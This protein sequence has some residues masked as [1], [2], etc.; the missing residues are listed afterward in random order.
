MNLFEYVR[1][2]N[3]EGAVDEA[4]VPDA[5]YLAGGTTLV[6]LMRL[7]VER[8]KRVVDI[9]ALP[10][11][12]ISELP[13]GGVRIGALAKNSDVAHHRVI[14]E[15]FPVLSEA[16]LS[17]ASPQ[18]RNMASVS[19]NML[20]GTRCPYFRD[21]AST[22]NKRDPGSGCAALDGYNR[23]HAILGTSDKC[24][25]THPSDMCVALVALDAIVHV[26]AEGG[27]TR[28]IAMADF[29]TLPGQHPEIE[30][31]LARGE[32]ITHLELPARAFAAHSRYVKVRD[33]ASFAFA[34]ASAAVAL[35][36]HGKTI[37]DARIALGGVAT[38]PWR[39]LD[40]EK[41]LVGKP[42]TFDTFKQAAHA[43]LAGART[44]PDN[45]F[46]VELA[47]RTIVRALARAGGLA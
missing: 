15:R 11:A 4:R 5:K 27:K 38:K 26:R 30:S 44:R 21:L 14:V 39:A 10:L 43:A 25:A 45:A 19:G 46:K 2:A 37:R 22:C 12:Q 29:H 17:G 47:T 32:L 9:N 3:E 13:A 33:R 41:A 40:A 28:Q 1:A 18:V 24:I 34:L 20:Q 35:E 36:L 6:D 7:E 8:P 31:Q 16:L 42:A 23:S